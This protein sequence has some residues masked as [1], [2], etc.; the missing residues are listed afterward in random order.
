M[1]YDFNEAY[2]EAITE[3]NTHESANKIHT[4]LLLLT[5]FPIFKNHLAQGRHI[6]PDVKNPIE[7]IENRI[8]YLKKLYHAKELS[9]EEYLDY[10]KKRNEDIPELLQKK[11]LYFLFQIG[12]ENMAN[13]KIILHEILN[14]L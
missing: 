8:K 2:L 9:R 3:A 7:I 6:F 11:I 1:S 10:Y 12:T 4:L 13:A 14:E 5:Y